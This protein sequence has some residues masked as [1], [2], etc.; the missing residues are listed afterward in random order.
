MKNFL[1]LLFC[2]F[3][4]LSQ[5]QVPQSISYQG[6][7]RDAAG[8]VLINQA[9]AVKFDLH[10][11]STGGAV[12]FNEIHNVNTNS[13][14]LFSLMI[15]SVNTTGFTS[16]NW[17]SGPYFL[18]VSMDPTGGA[19]FV[20][21]GN[22]QLLS[23]PYALYAEKAGNASPTPTIAINAPNTIT[24]PS[25]G[26]YNINVPSTTTYTA[27][28]GIDLTGN[29]ITNTAPAITPTL[30][31]TGNNISI[32]PGNTQALPTYSLTQSGSNI[33]LLQDGS[34]IATVSLTP[35]T[36]YVAGSGISVT[37][38]TI[39]NTA[40]D[41]TVTITGAGVS[42]SYPNFSITPVASP[43][44]T[45]IQGNNVVLNQSGNTYTVAAVTPT[46]SVTGGSL[47]G[48]YPTQTL[49]IPTSSTT[50][51]TPST[52]ISIVGS[53]PNY[54]VVNTAPA[55]SQT[56]SA[57]GVSSVT[58]SAN[59]FTINTPMPIYTST[60]GV[61]SFGGTNTVVA[62]PS[63]SI[64]GN[65]IRS[66]PTTNTITL[67]FAT[68]T[69]TGTGIATV[70][71]AVNNFTVNVP[72]P[73]YAPATGILN[74]G[75]TNTVVVTPTL[76]LTGTTLT[77]GASTN[78]VNLASLPNNWTLASGALYP[79]TLTNSVAIGTSSPVGGKFEILHT[80]TTSNPT[81]HLRETAGGLNRIKFSNNTIP[82]K[83][84]EIAS[85]TNATDANGAY[86]V[87]Y[88]DGTT[89]RT[90]FLI[91]GDHKVVVHN[92][93]TA[94]ASLHVMD[95]TN[96]GNGIAS[97]GFN[98]AGILVLARNNQ[99]GFGS[100]LAINAADDIGRVS[101]AGFTG[102]TYGNGPRIT[103]KAIEAFTG[104]ANGSELIF[105]TV[106]A[107]TTSTQDVMKLRA[108]GKV[109]IINTLVIPTG[110]GAGKVLTSDL[111][112]N[113]S[114]Q[115]A[116]AASP[117]AYNPGVLYPLNNPSTDKVAIGQASASSMLDIMNSVTSTVTAS[118]VVNITNSNSSFSGNGVLQVNKTAGFGALIYATNTHSIG[119]G[120][121]I[122]MSNAANGSNAVQV[123]QFGLGNSGYFE[124]DNAS[125]NAYAVQGKITNGTPS[126]SA[127][128]GLNVSS[129]GNAGNFQI[130]NTSNSQSALVVTNDGLGQGGY[131]ENTNAS[132]FNSAVYAQSNGGG[133]TIS[134]N[135]SGTGGAAAFAVN[136]ATSNANAMYAVNHG[137]GRAAFLENTNS[138][139]GTNVLYVKNVGTGDAI[140]GEQWGTSGNTLRLS[141][142]NG[143]N[144]SP[145]I[146]AQK[147]GPGGVAFFENINT[148]T[149]ANAVA[150]VTYGIGS[151][152]FANN[153]GTGGHAGHFNIPGGST[154]TSAALLASNIASGNALDAQAG[155]GY[156]VYATNSSSVN[157]AVYA[158]N[159]GS[160]NGVYAMNNSSTTATGYFYNTGSYDGVGAY[161]NGG[162]AIYA[163]SSSSTGYS[164]IEGIHYGT[165]SGLL[166]T[167][168][169]GSSGN[170]ARFNNVEATNSS[171]AV[172]IT[173][174]GTGHG[175]LVTKPGG[176]TGGNAARF[177]NLSN[178]N[179]ADAVMVTNN[180][181]GAAVH[182]VSGPTVT[183]SSNAALWVENGHIKTTFTANTTLSAGGTNIG[184]TTIT[185]TPAA[186]FTCN[187]VSGVVDINFA[188]AVS[189]A[190]GQYVEVRVTFQ[191][192]YTVKPKVFAI[193][194]VN[195]L[196]CYISSTSLTDCQIVIQNNGGATTAL[197]KITF[198]YFV[199]E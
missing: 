106:A 187:D 126:S 7:A 101:F 90:E 104:S 141:S 153:M 179:S 160:G 156:G 157:A 20:S 93:N 67:P 82:N 134:G 100:R 192:A 186:G 24:N 110:A 175:L 59:S 136:N 1:T 185:R 190:N 23:V 183:G 129:S 170:V 10:Q 28:N 16:I 133:V 169:A 33:D 121:S 19:S 105:S 184:G 176:V 44:T 142:G 14:G 195:N 146:F 72:S 83:F 162:R 68:I 46:L 32:N 2:S 52:G 48:V 37:S 26:V 159:S 145:T 166:L 21:V 55:I 168:P 109:E 27:G 73:T 151:T 35:G 194:Q 174:S 29:I 4:F 125:S 13:F 108:D 12:V 22:Q 78:S 53:A 137:M 88:H 138:S 51:L 15:G 140:F 39:A 188:P 36:S 122:N 58:A 89:Y 77:S 62:T 127:V 54:T 198:N 95:T 124:I 139:N 112:G 102:G 3:I 135:N 177:E 147:S 99:P 34:S 6:V 172:W 149:N 191:K 150:A 91:T 128:K 61:L 80:A 57:T 193:C 47:T 31:V 94:L 148:T 132:N 199:I 161:S 120:L 189:I 38:G 182:A 5:A 115:N 92:M 86:S 111:I 171:D 103:A 131:F 76:S 123:V 42:G 66:G 40:P 158:N 154:N 98:R 43:S 64:L 87:N 117:W 9:I 181:T 18:E 60:T 116:A 155:A 81:M 130:F 114:W 63:L 107:G 85:Q 197:A 65:V 11:G 113:A 180:G 8:T 50:V 75:G 70:T 143:T 74:F 45:L 164:G 71:T 167:K 118:P 69:G 84:F 56:I 144:T 178:A 25:A 17:G 165:G 41:Q 97:E 119:D 173:N 79:T 96:N 163:Q 49:T 196:N 30:T 152:I